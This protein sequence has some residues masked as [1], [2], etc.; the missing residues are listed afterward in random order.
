MTQAKRRWIRSPHLSARHSVSSNLLVLP[1][2][3]DATDG[4][5]GGCPS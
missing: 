3:P 2:S 1:H 5:A 4:G